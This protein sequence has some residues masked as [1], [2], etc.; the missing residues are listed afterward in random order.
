M[1]KNKLLLVFLLLF[2]FANSRVLA[3]TF[4]L[5]E[6]VRIMETTDNEECLELFKTQFLGK[7]F[8]EFDRFAR[9]Q[10]SQTFLGDD[11]RFQKTR[12]LAKFVFQMAK[13]IIPIISKNN[14][15]ITT[16]SGRT[17]D[18]AEVAQYCRIIAGKVLG[19]LHKLDPD[20]LLT[21]NAVTDI[22]VN[23]LGLEIYRTIE[24]E[25]Q[26]D[27]EV[28]P[29]QTSAAG[30]QNIKRTFSGAFSRTD[31]GSSLSSSAVSLTQSSSLED[32]PSSLARTPSFSTSSR[33]SSITYKPKNPKKAKI[34]RAPKKTGQ[35][36]WD[37][38]RTA[39]ETAGKTF[40]D[41]DS[42]ANFAA[43]FSPGK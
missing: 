41:K 29:T 1:L 21:E 31:S 36:A 30:E 13:K 42:V 10:T 9:S 6:L 34:D 33:Q 25:P 35:N 27:S 18:L 26:D 32:D 28:V 22:D 5:A 15:R 7:N 8:R 17:F 20:E 12:P 14:P 43:F 23:V 3:L 11:G 37:K 40:Y 16:L 4:D 24:D 38:R 19:K 2:G 39:A